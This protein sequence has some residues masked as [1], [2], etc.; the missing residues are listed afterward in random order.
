MLY[1]QFSFMSCV[2]Q[3][4]VCSECALCYVLC[5][6][7]DC[8]LCAVNSDICVYYLVTLVV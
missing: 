6:A 7:C 1:V 8:V 2:T 4:V 5:F 3:D